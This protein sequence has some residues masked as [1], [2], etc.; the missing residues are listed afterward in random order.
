M[1]HTFRII[2]T[3]TIRT[4][5]IT[6]E[7]TIDSKVVKNKV[8]KKSIQYSL[9]PYL[10]ESEEF[11]DPKKNLTAASAWMLLITLAHSVD[12]DTGNLYIDKKKRMRLAHKLGVKERLVVLNLSNLVKADCLKRVGKGCYLINPLAVFIGSFTDFHQKIADYEAV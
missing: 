1:Q 12:R 4:D 9:M 11:K 5:P 3:E 6:G 2:E 8:A 10:L 7:V